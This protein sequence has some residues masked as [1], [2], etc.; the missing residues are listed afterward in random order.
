VRY[1]TDYF[2]KKGIVPKFYFVVDRIDL[3]IQTQKEFKK[4]GLEVNTINSRDELIKDFKN[5][6]SKAGITVMNIQK[7]S[8]DTAVLNDS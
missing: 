6:T 3:S 1:L 2:S 5:N 4:R 8:E 7:F